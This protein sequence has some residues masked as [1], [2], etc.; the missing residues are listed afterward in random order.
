MRQSPTACRTELM[1][2]Q[3]RAVEKVLPARVGALFMEMGTGKSRTAIELVLRRAELGRVSNAVWF[4]P[5][6]LRDTVRQEIVKHTCCRARD[7]DVFDDNTADDNLPD[8]FWHVV[9]IESMSQSGRLKMAAA[10]LMKRA[11]FAIVDESSYIKGHRSAR[12]CWITRICEPCRYRLILTGTPLTQGVVD[13]YAQMRFLSP[14]ILG[15]QSFY[16]FARNHLEYSDKFPGMIVRAHNTKWLAAKM[17]P[18]VYQISK[19]ECLDLPNKLYESRWFSMTGE[20]RSL[21]DRAKEEILLGLEDWDDFT[22]TTIFKLFTALQQIACG[23]WREQVRGESGCTVMHT[24]AHDR[25]QTLA[26]VVER[27]AAN[28][29]IIVWVKD[30]HSLAAIVEHLGRENCA[31][32][33]GGVSQKR[34][35]AELE[36]FRGGRRFLVATPS[37]AG[38]GLTL[39]EACHVVFYNEGFKYSE[40]LQAEDRCH[41]IGQ[42]R[43]VTYITI[44]CRDSIDERIRDTLDRKGNV[45]Q[46]FKAEIDKVRDKRGKVSKEQI[47]KIMEEL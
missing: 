2:H 15:Y 32:F 38:H 6:S 40:R 31:Q 17:Q 13:L 11:T 37:S 43:P 26:E 8:C 9:G 7:I 24:A 35:I 3:M 34:R 47:G 23:Y 41:R 44:A 4:C 29:K 12:T 33:H 18:Y 5:V 20:Q 39:N 16:S 27:I 42:A 46:S 10:A 28:E 25:L 36:E 19:S 21:Y 14:E 30:R 22:S 1:P 45:L